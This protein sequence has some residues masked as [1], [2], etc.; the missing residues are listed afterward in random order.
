MMALV[1]RETSLV[2]ISPALHSIEEP[3]FVWPLEYCPQGELFMAFESCCVLRQIL[4]CGK[5]ISRNVRRCLVIGRSSF[6]M[7]C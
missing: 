6:A 1:D 5:I 7:C 2:D 4:N 3:V